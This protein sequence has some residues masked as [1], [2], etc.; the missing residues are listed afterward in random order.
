[1]SLQF[2]KVFGDIYCK[3]LKL[4]LTTTICDLF[5]DQMQYEVFDGPTG[6]ILTGHLHL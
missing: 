4:V 5:Q 1:M 6:K 3:P 2:V